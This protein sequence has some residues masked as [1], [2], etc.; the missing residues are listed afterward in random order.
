MNVINDY[1]GFP[2]DIALEIV[3]RPTYASKEYIQRYD[4]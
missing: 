3:Q 2:E 1:C 4:I